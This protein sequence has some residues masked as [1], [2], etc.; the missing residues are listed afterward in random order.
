MNWKDLAKYFLHGIVFSLLFV[1]LAIAWI[2]ILVILVGL[3][4]IIGLIIGLGLLF[5]IIGFLNSAITAY[6]WFEMKTSFWDLLFHGLTL[7]IILLI[8]NGIFITLP[9][10]ALPGVA[11]TV[12]TTII[13]SFVDGFVAKN[14]AGWWKQEYRKSRLEGKEFYPT[15]ICPSCKT[16]I[17]EDYQQC[18]WC[19][20]EQKST[21]VQEE[22]LEKLRDVQLSKK[23]IECSQ[24]GRKVFSDFKVCPY[25]GFELTPSSS[26]S[27]KS[28]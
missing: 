20:T 13:A 12:I 18:P 11:T 16:K 10:L 15:I 2:F 6:L 7:F 4:F 27:H 3:G 23:N 14:V 25:C 26:N 5:I 1:L 24:C 19:G 28:L 9:S 17:S 21:R 8:A 22:N